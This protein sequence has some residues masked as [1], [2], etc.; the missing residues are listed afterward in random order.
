LN[1]NGEKGKDFR[2]EIEG[3]KGKREQ[4]FKNEIVREK[5]E[6]KG[7]G[8]EFLVRIFWEI[9]TGLSVRC[10]TAGSRQRRNKYRSVNRNF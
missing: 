3:E 2:N 4:V 7:G 1:R 10:K 5:G 8:V 6:R 9:E